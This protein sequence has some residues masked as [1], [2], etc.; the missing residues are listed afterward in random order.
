MITPDMKIGII[1]SFKDETGKEK[2][3]FLEGKIK[4]I[5]I[6]KTKTSIYTDSI[7]NLDAVELESNTQLISESKLILLDE[8]F[9]TDGE[10]S[11]HC[12]QVVDYW[13]EYGAKS[14]L[15]EREQECHSIKCNC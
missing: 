1:L 5:N 10:Y 15:E 9:I 13:N 7:A 12:R 2:F 8:P 3:K 14:V 6:G 4:K 11:E